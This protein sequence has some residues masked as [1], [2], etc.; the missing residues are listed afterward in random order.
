MDELQKNL[1]VWMEYYNNI[2][3]HQG[4]E[5]EGRTPLATLTDGKTI[6]A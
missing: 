1:D 5:C 4:K 2:R 6:W 3:T